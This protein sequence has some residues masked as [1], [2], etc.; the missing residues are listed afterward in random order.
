M[1]IHGLSLS[2]FLYIKLIIFD[3]SLWTV[4]GNIQDTSGQN[5][6]TLREFNEIGN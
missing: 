5:K 4:S 3:I 2:L 6:N 1:R